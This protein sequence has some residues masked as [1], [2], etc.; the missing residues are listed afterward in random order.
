MQPVLTESAP[1]GSVLMPV[2]AVLGFSRTAAFM[3][4]IN[5]KLTLEDIKVPEINQC[6][7]SH[8]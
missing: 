7:Q 5:S 2:Q 8:R 3:L 6:Y 1:A 4:P